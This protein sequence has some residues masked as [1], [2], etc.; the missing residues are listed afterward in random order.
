MDPK[1]RVGLI[2]YFRYRVGNSISSPTTTAQ[3][4]ANPTPSIVPS[5]DEESI[6]VAL[7]YSI[8]ARAMSARM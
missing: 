1:K 2:G 6:R 4:T 7:W 5:R 3:I 8:A